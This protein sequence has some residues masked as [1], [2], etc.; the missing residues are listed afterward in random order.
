[1]A[2]KV[3]GLAPKQGCIKKNPPVFS[4][5]VFGRV[6]RFFICT[7]YVF[8]GD[9]DIFGFFDFIIHSI[10]SSYNLLPVT[11]HQHITLGEA[12]SDNFLVFEKNYYPTLSELIFF[13]FPSNIF[14][15]NS[16]RIGF[17]VCLK[18]S[19]HYLEHSVAI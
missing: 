11:T 16:V 14:G 10:N 18:M 19:L 4:S 2:Q 5:G 17:F 1:M 3:I 12:S 9:F 15:P 7:V 6:F 8:F 13:V